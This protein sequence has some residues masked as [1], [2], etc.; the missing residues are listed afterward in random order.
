MQRTSDWVETI[1]VLVLGM[2]LLLV[3]EPVTP[4]QAM[5]A[6]ILAALV[7]VIALINF[8]NLRDRRREGDQR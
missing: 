6:G 8:W 5:F 3:I 7:L 4:L 2:L 1:G